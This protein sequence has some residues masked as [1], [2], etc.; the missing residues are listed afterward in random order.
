M[1]SIEQIFDYHR[2][3]TSLPI[4]KDK[5]NSVMGKAGVSNLAILENN[6]IW[7]I[8]IRTGWTYLLQEPLLLT[9][10]N[11]DPNMDK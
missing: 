3:W 4:H 8:E 5:H 7:C 11:F 6:V 2:T 10:N 9:W 1:I